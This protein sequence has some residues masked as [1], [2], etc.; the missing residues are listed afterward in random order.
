ML[1]T[2][3]FWACSLQG[4]YWAGENELFVGIN[5][6]IV[7]F[8]MLLEDCFFNLKTT[9]FDLFKEPLPHLVISKEIFITS[10]HWN[11]MLNFH[12]G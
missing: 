10:R 1:H 2:E 4:S 9:N 6:K 8:M 7:L 5:I 11:N 3:G 12:N